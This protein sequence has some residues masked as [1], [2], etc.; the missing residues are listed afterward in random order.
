M[1]IIVVISI[2]VVIIVIVLAATCIKQE[3]CRK[4]RATLLT[5]DK[6]KIINMYEYVPTMVSKNKRYIVT[7]ND[8]KK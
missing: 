4:S 8:R 3:Q 7:T 6:R 5:F 2:V 1:T